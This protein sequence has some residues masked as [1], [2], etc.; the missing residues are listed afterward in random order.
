MKTKNITIKNV[1]LET[2]EMI[3]DIRLD[4]RRQLSAILQDCVRAYWDT[5][6][7]DF[8]APGHNG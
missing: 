4:E 3:R 8:D 2:L 7:A 1:D 5:V 6:Y